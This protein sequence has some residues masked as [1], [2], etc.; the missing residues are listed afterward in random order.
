MRRAFKALLSATTLTF[1]L[2]FGS[3]SS[4]SAQTPA[5]TVTCVIS[6]TTS[7]FNPPGV[8]AVSVDG[9]NVGSFQFGP[10]GNQSL[11]FS[12]TQASHSFTFTAS[13]QVIPSVACSGTFDSSNKTNFA[14]ALFVSPTG[15]TCSLT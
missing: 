1:G 14:P 9:S 10:G 6:A 5:P 2:S 8:M 15:T 13:F 3:L 7:P 11:S 12:C 4:A